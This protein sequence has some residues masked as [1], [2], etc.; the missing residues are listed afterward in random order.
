MSHRL[1]INTQITDKAIAEAAL[2]QADIAFDTRGDSIYLKSG[3][4]TGTVINTKNGS[5]TSGDTD[6]HRITDA[7]LGVLRQYYAEAK[8]KAECQREGVDILERS[9]EKV[10]GQTVVVLRCQVA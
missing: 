10:N 5:V 1:T 9:E 3:S 8:Y 4:Y 6:Y 7:Q 2:R